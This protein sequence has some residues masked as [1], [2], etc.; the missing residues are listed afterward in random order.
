[1]EEMEYDVPV[2]LITG[3]LESGKTTFLNFTIAQEYFQIPELTLLIACE[4]GEEEYDKEML[5]KYHTVLEVVEE[6]EDFT[7]EYLEKLEQKYHPGRV[8]LEFNPLWSVSQFEQMQLPKDW[9]LAQ[10]I[11]ITDASCF[12]IYMNNLKSLFVEMTRNAELVIFNRCD[13]E[14][15]PLANFR[16]GIKVTNPGCEIQFE[17]RDGQLI[18]IFEDQM[19]YDLEA[20]I[21][22]IEDVDYG[23]FYVDMEDHPE[24]YQGKTVRFK[25]KVLRSKDKEAQ[26]FVPARKVMTCCADDMSMLGFLCEYPKTSELKTGQWVQ[27]TARVGWKYMK[28]Y[29]GKG[30]VYQDAQIEF[31]EAPQDELVYFN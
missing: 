24:R 1:M 20:E 21:I 30:P 10:Q 14:K 22:E 6:P 12:Q 8:I 31:C 4:E 2:Y 18:D 25:G 26:Y 15:H 5:A 16:R 29:R 28:S 9:E 11:V 13:P 7:S 23:I 19:P 27:V 17:D 3:F